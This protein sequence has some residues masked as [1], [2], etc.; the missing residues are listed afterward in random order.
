MF[1]DG[2]SGSQGAE[3]DS[4]LTYN[5]SSGNL[6]SDSFTG[7]SFVQVGTGITL[8]SSGNATY[9]GIVT[10]QT[11]VGDGSGLTNVIGS[12]SGI[13]VEDSGSTVG[14]AGTINFANGLD[15]TDISAGIV[16]V[17]TATTSISAPVPG[18]AGE[19][20]VFVNTAVSYT[21]LRAHETREDGV[22]PLGL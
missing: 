12:G 22:C 9:T 1:V 17:S 13:V 14:T 16:T 8:S 3:I 19:S 6:T 2:T 18:S 7:Q 10:A 5:P 15:V 4:S 20:K 21:H 11:F